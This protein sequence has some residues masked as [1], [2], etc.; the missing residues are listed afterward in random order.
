MN[1]LEAEMDIKNKVQATEVVEIVDC[2]RASERT[3]GVSWLILL[4]L[5]TP[6]LDKL[7]FV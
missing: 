2:G 3:R 4:E 5:G 6:P 7:F 1:T